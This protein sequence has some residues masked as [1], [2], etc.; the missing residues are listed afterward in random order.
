MT[1]EFLGE[2]KAIMTPDAVLVA[3]TFST[4]A[5]YDHESV[6]Y[7]NVFG[8]LFNFKI[9]TSGNRIIITSL[10]P[11]PPRGDLT[12]AARNIVGRL[13][14]YNIPMLEYPNRMS[15]RV[16]WDMSKRVLTDQYSPANLL[17][18]N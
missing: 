2:V 13:E 6:T 15:T 17:R 18:D 1:R 4:S 3:N 5:F 8:E 14:K 9:P 7:R 11:L 10:N 12:S 16:D